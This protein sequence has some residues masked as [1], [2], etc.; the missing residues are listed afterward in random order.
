MASFD[1]FT[2]RGASQT[3]RALQLFNNA[4]GCCLVILSVVHCA[5]P[6]QSYACTEAQKQVRSAG[7]N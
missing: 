3:R 5:A 6:A 4:A 1:T 7:S 2:S